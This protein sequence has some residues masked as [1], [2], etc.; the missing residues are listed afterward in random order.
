MFDFYRA[1]IH[2]RKHVCTHKQKHK[3]YDEI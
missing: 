2:F 1:L 3:M